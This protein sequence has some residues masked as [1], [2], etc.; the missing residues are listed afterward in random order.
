MSSRN[1][2]SVPRLLAEI[3]CIEHLYDTSKATN[4]IHRPETMDLISK[5]RVLSNGTYKCLS[6]A[7]EP[8]FKKADDNL[9]EQVK[10]LKVQTNDSMDQFA[11][12]LY[13]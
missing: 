9:F 10:R 4:T 12:K 8:N 5:F 7:T 1:N 13:I 6:V 3:V 2:A 11:T